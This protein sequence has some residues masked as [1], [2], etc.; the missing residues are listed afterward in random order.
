M[1]TLSHTRGFASPFYLDAILNHAFDLIE[2]PRVKVG[3]AEKGG[4]DNA[5]H[6]FAAAH[7]AV[8]GDRIVDR[9][10]RDENLPLAN[11]TDTSGP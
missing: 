7:Q 1:I 5:A 4:A 6:E 9:F 8:H 3:L 10:K 2:P 11:S